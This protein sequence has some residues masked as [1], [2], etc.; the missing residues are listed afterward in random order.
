MQPLAR[1]LNLSETAFVVPREDGEFDLRW[2]TPAVEVD[3]CG[4]ATLATAHVLWEEE[5]TDGPIGFHTRSGR[6]EAT[7]E[8][9]WIALDFPAVPA[10]A[11]APPDGVAEAL[12]VEPRFVGRSGQDDL[13]VEVRDEATVRDLEP[14]IEAL[15][16]IP[17]RGI[18]VT[19]EASGEAYDFVSRFFG[20][21]VGIDEDPVTGSAHCTLAPFWSERMGSPELTGYQAS[22]RGGIV[23]VRLSGDRVILA[24]R[25]VTVLRATLQI[26]EGI[27]E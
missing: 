5:L 21:N 10:E 13:L 22:P 24:G 16:K 9:E 12:G 4:H 19:S 23:R 18:V 8:G 6:L 1:E 26:E 20:P 27:G 3:L 25:A 17:A 14:D 15:G 7:R 2:F 11:C